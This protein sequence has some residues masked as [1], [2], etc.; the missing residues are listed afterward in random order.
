MS[1]GKVRTGLIVGWEVRPVFVETDISNGIPLFQ[2]VGYLSSEVKEATARVRSGIRNAGFLLPPKRVTVNL[3]PATIRKRGTS[4]DLP[5]AISVLIAFG[6]VEQEEVE[7][8]FFVGELGLDGS[9]RKVS[10]ILPMLLFAQERGI[11]RCMIPYENL[12]E[13]SLAPHIEVIG[14]RD[15]KECVVFL[16]TGEKMEE[17]RFVKKG[18]KKEETEKDF[19]QVMGQEMAKRGIEISV[20][21]GHNLFMVGPPG[22]G[23]TMLAE[24]IPTILP[25]LELWERIEIAKIYS[26][27]GSFDETSS[28]VHRP[29]RSV[30]H[31]ATRAGLVGGGRIPKPGE[32]SLAHKGV[33]FLDEMAEFS[34]TV[35]EGLR[36]PMEKGWMEIQREY[37]SLRFPADFMLIG[38]ANPCPCGNFPDVERCHCTQKEMKDYLGK[39]SQ[40]ILDRIDL[41]ME[42]SPVSYKDLSRGGKAEDSQTIRSRIARVREI[43]KNRSQT[44]GT[45][46]NGRLNVSELKKVCVLGERE[47]AL[48]EKAFQKLRLTA[49]TYHKV[50]KVARTIA[51]MEESE[52]IQEKHLREALGYRML[53]M[54]R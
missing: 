31:T 34:K 26:I 52:K 4:Y 10:G 3:A 54:K 40:P 12:G 7:D 6:F 22:S 11:K 42:L 33:L 53:E 43:Q 14:V 35:L 18:K 17:G 1:F 25:D 30:H 20:S 2:M 51:D 16:K 44:L 13:G 29:F 8:V 28:M 32:I 37:G 15:V 49:R 5:I 23:K 24:R 21:G 19:N 48:M 47:E 41:C 36:Q 27:S 50:L 39:I 9:V 46:L 45:P 38:A